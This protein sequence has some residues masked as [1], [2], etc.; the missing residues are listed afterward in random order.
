MTPQDSELLAIVGRE[1]YRATLAGNA[2]PAVQQLGQR[3][4]NPRPGDLVLEVSSWL[5][6]DPDSIGRLKRVTGNV[7][8]GS[9]VWHVEPLS[10][11]GHEVTWGNVEFVSLPDRRKWLEEQ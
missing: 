6:F 9:D 10:K 3:M 7:S 1:L 8:D 11:P 2:A 4:R 5:G